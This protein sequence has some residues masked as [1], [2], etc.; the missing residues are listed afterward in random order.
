MA[1]EDRAVQSL[2]L[3]AKLPI[4]ILV[5]GM[6]AMAAA[7]HRAQELYDQGVDAAVGARPAGA[8]VPPPTAAS[9]LSTF[10]DQEQRTMSEWRG[11]GPLPASMPEPAATLDLHFVV[12]LLTNTRTGAQE[13]IGYLTY[14]DGIEESLFSGPPSEKTAYFTLRIEGLTAVNVANTGNV[15][16]QLRPPGQKLN[17]YLHERPDNDWSRPEGFSTGKMVASYYEQ[18]A[19]LINMGP[20]AES[21]ATFNLVD[22][23]EFTFKGKTY[24]FRRD[25]PN[26]VTAVSYFSTKPL[27]TGLADFPEAFSGAGVGYTIAASD[28]DRCEIAGTFVDTIVQP[29]RT[30]NAQFTFSPD[31]GMVGSTF[32]IDGK[33]AVANGVWKRTGPR[34]Y[35]LTFHFLDYDSG[36]TYVRLKVRSSIRLNESLDAYSG[37]G[38]MDYYDR[39]GRV[40]NSIRAPVSG[41]RMRPEPLSQG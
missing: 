26:G 9:M 27:P 12:R 10:F 37:E 29:T 40:V 13:V 20:T 3:L 19:Q 34:Q 8:V 30:F 35:S 5:S 38:Q 11:A 22:G 16:V 31:G 1:T 21:T 18:V 25:T 2:A 23:A 33:L 4:G 39:N 24:D 15:L 17:I 28:A 41:K 32:T 6:E 7:A 14:K 36:T